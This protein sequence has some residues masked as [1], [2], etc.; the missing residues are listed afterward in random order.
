MGKLGSVL[1]NILVQNE[2]LGSARA[3][4][5]QFVSLASQ[6][7]AVISRVLLPVNR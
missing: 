2:Y 3:K 6:V 4:G 1:M 7:A 5:L